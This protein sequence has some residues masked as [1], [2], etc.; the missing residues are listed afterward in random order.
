MDW[1]AQLDLGK[2]LLFTLIL[3]RVSGLVMT[4]PIYG[5]TDIPMQVRALLGVVLAVLILPSQW[6][7][8]VAY[9]ETILN[10]LVFLGSELVVGLSLGLG[11]VI[12]FAGIEAAG[13]VMAQVSGLSIAEV[14]DPS[15]EQ[16]VS[17]FSRLLFLVTLAIFVT[18]GGHRMVM[19]GLLDTFQSIPPGSAAMPESLA[20]TFVTLVTQSFS[21]G[22]RAAAPLVAALLLSNLVLGLI[23][24]TLPQLN[25]LVIGFG[26][27]SLLTFGAL[28]LSIGAAA[29]VF[30]DQVAPALEAVL[31]AWR[32]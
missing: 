30:E 3:T 22:I 2:F 10:Y 18:I 24:R 23:G 28:C 20:E 5:T 26:L 11:V 21:L 12:L 19:A 1:L 16:N 7:V 17:V 8:S 14:F 15:Q 27:N 9:P 4:A 25:I 29:W 6:N 32:G 13:Q 31:E